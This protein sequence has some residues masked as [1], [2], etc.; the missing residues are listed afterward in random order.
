MRFGEPVPLDSAQSK[1]KY[2]IKKAWRKPISRRDLSWAVIQT[3]EFAGLMYLMFPTEKD[4]P[5]LRSILA[6]VL[7][8]LLNLIGSYL[9]GNMFAAKK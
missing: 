9:F 5:I 6:G 2:I 8:G 4:N 1:S 3:I 7:F